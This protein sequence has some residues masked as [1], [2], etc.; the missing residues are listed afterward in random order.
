MAAV[1]LSTLGGEGSLLE[2]SFT[3]R[4]RAA[5]VEVEAKK[6]TQNSDKSQFL[7]RTRR[8]K[9]QNKCSVERFTFPNKIL[10]RIL[11][12]DYIPYIF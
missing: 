7:P 5:N 11:R 1:S 2:T 12:V 8:L 9:G 3:I 4:E 6:S 10:K